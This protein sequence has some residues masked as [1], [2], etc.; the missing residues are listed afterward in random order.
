MRL[1]EVLK[2]KIPVAKHQNMDVVE[3][4]K[5]RQRY[6]L[7]PGSERMDQYE[8]SLFCTNQS[9]VRSSWFKNVAEK[10]RFLIDYIAKA[11]INELSKNTL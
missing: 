6:T 3:G 2:R 9:G 11:A 10:G 4:I 8:L 7:S 1:R 5:V